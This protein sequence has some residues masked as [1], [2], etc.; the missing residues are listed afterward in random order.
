MLILDGAMG[1]MIQKYRLSEADFRGTI[2]TQ[3][4]S[5]L[6]GNNDILCLTQPDIIRE[7]HEAYLAAGADIIET[8]TFNANRISQSDYNLESHVTPLNFAAARLAKQAAE[9]FTASTP[10]KP[11]FVAGA[12]GPTNK[13]L[14]ISPDVN[15]PG[16]R[17]AT[18]DEM[19]DTYYEQAKALMEG[20]V[21]I[22]L[23]ETVFDTLNAKAAIYAC[24]ELFEQT[25][26]T[27]PI[28][29][30]GTI[31]D[32]SG[33][34]LSGQTPEAFLISVAHAP[35]LSIG[36]NCALGAK[37][38]TPHIQ[39]IAQKTDLFVSAYPNA[40]LPDEFGEYTES[41]EIN[42][43][44]I[45]T[46]LQNGWVNIIGGCCGTT[47]A[48][49]QYLSQLAEKY[50]PRV[51]PVL[52]K[53]PAFSG[54]EA[55]TVFPGSNFINVGERTNI[56]G[57]KKF[58]ELIVAEKMEDAV[59]I[60]K[61]QV[62]NGA[63]IIDVN[64]DEGMIDSASAMQ[65]FMHL[66]MS[67]PDIAKVPVMVDSSKWEVIEAGLKCL[68]G[69]SIVNSISLK[70][71]EEKFLATAAKAKKLGAAVIVMAFDEEGQATT[72]EKRI[73]ICKRAYTL[74]TEKLH[75][76][77]TD[78]IFDPNILTVGTGMEEHNTYAID[79]IRATEWIKQNLPG[80]LVSGGVSNISFAFQGNNTVR[81]AMHSAFLFHAIKA[82][83]D[84]GIV[85]A[86][87]IDIY[88]NIPKPLLEKIEDVLFNRNPDATERLV[89]FAEQLKAPLKTSK[90][91]TDAWRNNSVEDRLSYAL[92]KGITDFIEADVEEAR[93]KYAKPLDIIEGPLMAG[94][95]V[96]GD[97]FGSGKMFLPQV[98]KSAM[99]MKKAVAY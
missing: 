73:A 5:D 56:T 35:L 75:F 65:H 72:F 48:H 64:M 29:L 43:N 16:Y 55:F 6:K 7:I 59:G 25:G 9:K 71:G 26:Q 12:I 42:G 30:S 17:A 85:N 53:M 92:V 27:I 82:G 33:R 18:F 46:Y 4:T 90:E 10:N 39:T 20:G 93:L 95:N 40:G 60:A 77:P 50:P 94:M 44:Y 98:V 13:T 63:Q 78:I 32:A 14:S 8:N 74:L 38:L 76:E 15:N 68:Q 47:P 23:I 51:P 1:T 3:H 87:M 69:K 2:F 61:Q 88:E 24:M 80:S 19:A 67:E 49:I 96:V 99:V 57:S 81:E 52:P 58:R 45:V 97:L 31:T 22:L 62:E 89:K 84:M 79:F 36:F 66:I 41:P 28:M 86:G 54:L 83:M 11:R 91:Q 70:E 34:T 37:Q 21:D